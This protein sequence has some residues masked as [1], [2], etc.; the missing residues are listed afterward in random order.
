VSIDSPLEGDVR[1]TLCHI[2][3]LECSSEQSDSL[4]LPGRSTA[5]SIYSIHLGTSFKSLLCGNFTLKPPS[6]TRAT[7]M[8]DWWRT[9]V[10]LSDFH[11]LDLQRAR[12]KLKWRCFRVLDKLVTVALIACY[13]VCLIKVSVAFHS[14]YNPLGIFLVFRAL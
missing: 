9:K 12:I 1:E 7:G 13:S 10:R 5:Y 11:M 2:V 6:S 8:V 14:K 3:A 4:K